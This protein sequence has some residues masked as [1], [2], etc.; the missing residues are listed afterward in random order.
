MSLLDV[1]EEVEMRYL[2]TCTHCRK[3]VSSL[4]EGCP[5]CGE[6]DHCKLT[7]PK[8]IYHLNDRLALGIRLTRADY[9]RKV[10]KELFK[11]RYEE[12]YDEHWEILEG[13]EYAQHKAFCKLRPETACLQNEFI[14]H[15]EAEKAL[16][17]FVHD[18]ATEG[19]EF[20]DWFSKA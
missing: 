15:S 19:M 11:E 4:E 3:A 18:K 16:A 20:D 14:T 10:A 9:H 2:W 7:N 8:I 1:V 12:E 13:E 17:E 6:S 5:K